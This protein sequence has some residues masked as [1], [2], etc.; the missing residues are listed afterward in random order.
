MSFKSSGLF[1]SKKGASKREIEKEGE[2]EGGEG[3]NKN[4]TR[5]DKKYF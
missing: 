5:H 3:E 1:Q 4:I 2:R